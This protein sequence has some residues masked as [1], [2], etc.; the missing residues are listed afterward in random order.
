MKQDIE[1]RKE[2]QF[3]A[4]P[5]RHPSGILLHIDTAQPLLRLSY[6]I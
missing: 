6:Y 2:G 3:P 5:V 1:V 4:K